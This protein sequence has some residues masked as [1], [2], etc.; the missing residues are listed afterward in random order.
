[1]TTDR[2]K[3]V[4]GVDG[5]EGSDCALQWA[6]AEGALRDARVIAVNAWEVPYLGELAGSRE[7]QS[8][9]VEYEHRANEVVKEA[10]DRA[11]AP[12]VETLVLHGTA[13]E[14]LETAA[15]DADLLVV[16]SRGRGGFAGLLLGSVSSRCAQHSPCPVV[17]VKA[18]STAERP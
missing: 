4:V 8:A 10:V 6:V 9:R 16:G 17:I 11:H 5:S 18:T 13:A 12:E 1:M 2:G 7:Y 15:R 3:I 14:M